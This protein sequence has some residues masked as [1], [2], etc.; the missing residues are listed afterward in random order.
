MG[1]EK[2]EETKKEQGKETESIKGWRGG[3]RK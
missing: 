2:E 1:K 3:E